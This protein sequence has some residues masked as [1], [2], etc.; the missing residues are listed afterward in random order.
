MSE[1]R[2]AYDVSAVCIMVRD[3]KKAST[4]H[5]CLKNLLHKLS[6]PFFRKDAAEGYLRTSAK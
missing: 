6:N 4:G 3:W 1:M 5:E 2:R